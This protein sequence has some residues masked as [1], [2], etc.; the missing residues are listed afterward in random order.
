MP[1][2]QNWRRWAIDGPAAHLEQQP[3]L[4]RA[5]FTG[6]GDCPA[7]AG[8]RELHFRVS[9][10]AWSW[11]F[12]QADHPGRPVQRSQIR[13]IVIHPGPHGLDVDVIPGQR[14]SS[15]QPDRLGPAAALQVTM[16][17]VPAF[18]HRS[19]LDAAAALG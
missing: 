19:L 2:D 10:S 15:R 17:G 13:A 7:R 6:V 1:G 4:L 12:P 18:I 16:M 9:G 3:E 8:F 5:E 14:A 11:C